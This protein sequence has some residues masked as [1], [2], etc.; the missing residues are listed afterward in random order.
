MVIGIQGSSPGA[1]KDTVYEII[2]EFAESKGLSVRRIAFGD[3]V[4]ILALKSLGFEGGDSELLAKADELKNTAI[5]NVSG[6]GRFST[7]KTITMRE[8]V[9]NFGQNLKNVSENIWMDIAEHNNPYPKES[10][11]VYTDIRFPNEAYYVSR[12]GKIV[13]I[14]AEDRVAKDKNVAVEGYYDESLIHKTITNNGSPEELK[15]KVIKY[16]REIYAW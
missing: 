3:Q 8:Y 9:Q 15:E 12:A 4:K 16:L 1:G 6:Q 2:K 5:I 10:L 14:D 7:E 13:Y 11:T